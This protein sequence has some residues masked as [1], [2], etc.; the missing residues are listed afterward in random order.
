M[1]QKAPTPVIVCGVT[2]RM[3]MHIGRGAHDDEHFVLVGATVRPGAYAEGDDLGELVATERMDVTIAG[4]LEQAAEAA[5]AGTVVIDFTSPLALDEHLAV[6]VD[7]QLPL[8]IGTTG[9]DGGQKERIAAAAQH[10]PV[11]LAPNT[12]LGANLLAALT[13]TAARALPE[14]DIEIVELHHRAKKDS[15]SGTAIML[16]R[17]AAAAREQEWDAVATLARAG[18]A[19][20]RPGKVGAFGVRGGTVPGEHTVYLFLDDERIELTH[21]VQD[22]A[23]FARGALAGARFL[24]GQPPGSYAMKDVLGLS[25]G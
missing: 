1:S 6:C 9:L 25:S 5:A 21:R 14:A 17:A 24:D 13:E 4:G 19:P 8:L 18:D 15:P 22:R 12:S 11:L 3:G 16:G 20:R 2:G 23:I 7:K 10:I